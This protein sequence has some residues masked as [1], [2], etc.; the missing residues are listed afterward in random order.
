MNC[1]W[2]KSENWY[3]QQQREEQENAC[4]EASGE[5]EHAMEEIEQLKKELAE[6]KAKGE[7]LANPWTGQAADGG[8]GL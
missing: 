6:A 2:L 3:L 1:S 7:G 4:M 5:L 8:D